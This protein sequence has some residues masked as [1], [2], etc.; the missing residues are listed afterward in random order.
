[1]TAT[2]S[3]SQN[4]A[5][6]PSVCILAAFILLL[7]Q[8]A[9]FGQ[10]AEA[11]PAPTHSGET[12]FDPMG[13]TE[14][15]ITG[16][17]G[18]PTGKMELG[19]ETHVMYTKGTVVLTEGRATA[20]TP[21]TQA[22]ASSPT[23]LPDKSEL[24]E[25]AEK[26]QRAIYEDQKAILRRMEEELSEKRKEL[27]EKENAP[28]RKEIMDKHRAARDRAYAN[29]YSYANYTTVLANLDRERDEEIA[30]LENSLGIPR[31]KEDIKRLQEDISEHRRKV[32]NMR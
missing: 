4:P 12:G 9:L 8:V 28:E 25:Q 30:R 11:N 6:P 19:E 10:N 29:Y 18:Q 27:S 32:Y 16:K 26:N 23:R 24:A 3:P 21:A 1:M 5:M 31:L 17:W 13:K 14:E 2:P 22:T 7:P 15:E 20:F